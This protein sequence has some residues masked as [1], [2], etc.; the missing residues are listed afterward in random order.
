MVVTD[1]PAG[2]ERVVEPEAVIA[3]D[4][5]GDIGECSRP[6]I[7]DHQVGIIVIAPDNVFGRHD[8]VAGNIVRDI[9]HTA[10]QQL[11]AGNAFFLERFAAARG[12]RFSEDKTALG[13][14][15]DD[16]CIL[17]HLG[18]HQAGDLGAEIFPPVR[19]ADA[20]AGDLAA[21]QMH[22]FHPGE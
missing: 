12:G 8:A 17:G 6:F 9:Q 18:L 13:A 15:R 11:V 3:G 16:D 20:A 14:D 10:D 2:C 7:S 22:A 19:P 1:R 5:V 21:A 4:P